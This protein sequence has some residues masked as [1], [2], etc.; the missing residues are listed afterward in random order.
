M[1]GTSVGGISVGVG[2]RGSSL[3]I[4]SAMVGVGVSSDWHAEVNMMSSSA[5]ITVMTGWILFVGFDI[6]IFWLLFIFRSRLAVTGLKKEAAREW[7][8]LNAE[9]RTGIIASAR[10]RYVRVGLA[11]FSR[12]K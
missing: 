8:I 5:R 12:I 9:S 4:V 3:R 10:N 7:G 2:T 11:V 6:C 1:G